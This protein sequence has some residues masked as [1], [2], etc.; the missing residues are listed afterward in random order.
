M[1]SKS[2]KIRFAI[3][4]GLG[5]SLL[6]LSLFLSGCQNTTQK[7]STQNS[8]QNSQIT[9]L[10]QTSSTTPYKVP[11]LM[12]HY[13]RTVD[14]TKDPLG[15][16]L[17]IEPTSFEH[18]L[19][20][21]VEKHYNSVHAADL[22]AAHDALINNSPNPLPENPIVITFDDGYEDFYTTALPLLK[23]YGFT[24][25]TAIITHKHDG[26]QF[27]TQDQLKE[28]HAAGIEILSHTQNH[29]DL[30][31]APDAKAEI[32]QSKVE[33]EKLLNTKIDGFVD[34]SGDYNL[35][36][37]LLLKLAGYKI[38]FT[39]KPGFANI[40]SPTADNMLQLH[41]LRIDNRDNLQTVER[42]LVPKP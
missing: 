4:L 31:I 7:S 30:R 19:K 37:I 18:I 36:T 38:A 24:A 35:Q 8:I 3:P 2:L 15:Y 5:L 12:F 1:S 17:S 26:V 41:R 27:M 42:M 28:I 11:V 32:D 6:V 10:T 25:S 34:P 23:K 9:S 13:V 20:Y 40:G 21:L 22:V 39:T 29:V 33:L 16:D 14:K